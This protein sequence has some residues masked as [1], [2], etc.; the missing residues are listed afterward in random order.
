[1]VVYWILDILF[2]SIIAYSF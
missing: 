2:Y 1:M